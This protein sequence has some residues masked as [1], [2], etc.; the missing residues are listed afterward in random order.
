MNWKEIEPRTLKLRDD[1]LAMLN[2]IGKESQA[3]NLPDVGETFI[4]A[5]GLLAKPDYD[6]VV[7]GEVKKGKSTFINAVIGQKILPTGVKET[8]SQVFRISNS[9]FESFALVFTDGAT[10]PV[11]R[12]QLS[13]Y[14]SQVDADLMGEPVFKGRQLDYIQINIPIELLPQGVSIVDTPGLGAFYKSHELI[15]H[16]YIRNAAAVVF[17]FDPSQP[18]VQQEKLFLGKVFSVTPFV[19]FIMTKIDCFDEAHWVSQI[20]RTETLLKDTFGKKCY[21]TPKVFPMAGETLFDAAKETEADAREELVE[22]SYFPAVQRE[23]LRVMYITVGLS[24]TRFA[25]NEANKQK[26]RVLSSIDDQLKMI[27]S[28]SKEEQ[29]QIKEK[30]A[31]IRQSFE[32]LWGTSSTKRKEVMQEVQGIIM[33]VNNRA[34]QLTSFTGPVYKKYLEQINALSSLDHI[35][36]Y[37]EKANKSLIREI[38]TGWQ[39]ITASAQREIMTVLNLIHADIE[40][41]VNNHSFTSSEDIQMVNLTFGE[42]FQSYKSKY[43]DAAI[44]TTVGATLLGL[45]GVTLAPFAPVIFL[46]TV[47]FG[48]LFGNNDAEQKAIEKNKVNLRNN[49]TS[50]MSGINA[51]LFH[52]PVSGGHKSIVQSFTSELS[53]AV[54]KAM[55]SMYETQK[56]Q[57]EAEQKRLDEQS[58][59]GA[60]QRKKELITVNEQ[61]KKWTDLAAQIAEA[62]SVLRSIQKA[63]IKNNE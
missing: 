8:T 16:R 2:V 11:T 61:R 57:I 34:I 27:S 53:V 38:S 40:E 21:T 33:G 52:A 54:E 46:G 25:W 31:A 56:K 43:F 23:L 37:S 12:E 3:T 36:R 17:I 60:E 19:M 39:A 10:E 30:R 41:V 9:K 15:T 58:R 14:G 51:Q 59:L 7:C 5:S 22:F 55:T 24:R 49:L 44:T 20:C 47:V 50:I 1:L 32:Q 42:K 63:L 62:E 29:E 48:F 26:G 18:M 13:R 28:S 45:A 35:K 6:I 4:L